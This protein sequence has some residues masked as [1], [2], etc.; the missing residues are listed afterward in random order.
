MRPPSQQMKVLL[1]QAV[2][3]TSKESA[4][5]TKAAKLIQETSAQVATRVEQQQTPHM[6]DALSRITKY[7]EADIGALRKTGMNSHPHMKELNV[8]SVTNEFIERMIQD[9]IFEQV[10]AILSPEADLSMHRALASL[11]REQNKEN[12][13]ARNAELNKQQG[14]SVQDYKEQ[15]A[16]IKKHD[17][18]IITD[19]VN[20]FDNR[21][22]SLSTYLATAST[23]DLMDVRQE[24]TSA[25]HDAETLF[26]ALYNPKIFCEVGKAILN[27][28]T[29]TYDLSKER[30]SFMFRSI[31]D[32][33][34]QKAKSLEERLTLI[35]QSSLKM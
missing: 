33:L 14:A 34:T 1:R 9:M 7:V 17:A 21:I 22:S 8:K 30:K 29:N 19:L 5:I 18:E 3:L 2:Q 10:S 24:I 28:F 20:F 32:D 31:S 13:R 35:S 4:S 15:I 16:D 6:R 25:E 12:M 11:A 26:A 23:E 27:N